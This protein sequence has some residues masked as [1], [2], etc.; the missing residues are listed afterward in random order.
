[1][2]F[3]LPGK[4]AISATKDSGEVEINFLRG[5]ISLSRS[6]TTEKYLFYILSISFSIEKSKERG[7][8]R[9]SDDGPWREA[10]RLR[11]STTNCEPLVVSFSTLTLSLTNKE[12]LLKS[13]RGNVTWKPAKLLSSRYKRYSSLVSMSGLWGGA[14]RTVSTNGWLLSFGLF[15]ESKGPRDVFEAFIDRAPPQRF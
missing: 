14:R 6:G 7:K 2:L 9:F 5:I 8:V 13:A 15:H 1:M 10:H 3:E 12:T 11:Y 4:Q